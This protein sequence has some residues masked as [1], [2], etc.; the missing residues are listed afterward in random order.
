M[1]GASPVGCR[2]AYL[3]RAFFNNVRF[4]DPFV[5]VSGLG[6]TLRRGGSSDVR[7]GVGILGRMFGSVRGG[8]CS[9]RMSHGITGTLLPLCT[10]VVPTKRHPT[11]CSIVR[12]RCGNSCG[13]CMST[14]CSA[15]VLTGRTGFSGF[16]GG[17]AMGTVR[18]SVTARCSHTG[19]SGCAGLTRRV[20]G[21][22]RRLTLLRGA[23][24]H[25]LNRV[26]LPMPSCPST[27]FAVHLACN[28]IG[29]CDPGSKMCCGC[30]A[31]ASKVLR[32]RGP[33]SHR[34][35][36][37]T[38]LGRLVRGGSFKHCTLPGNRVPIYFLSAGS[39]AN[40]GSKDPMLG[41]GNRLVNYTFSNG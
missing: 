17:P 23:C 11:V 18:G 26:G 41:R 4:N 40:N 35:I 5:M 32:G 10:R 34:F 9:R 39:V 7:T 6:R 21:L 14:V 20:K 31:A 2:R 36:M 29:P 16:V 25:K 22:P 38:G 1:T 27:G 8:S 3:A 37:P 12:G 28:G 30:C 19:F 15:S 24:V 33:R 13:T